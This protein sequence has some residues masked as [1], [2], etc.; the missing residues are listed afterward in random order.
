MD[1][2]LDKEK[3]YKI[4][5]DKLLELQKNSQDLTETDWTNAKLHF[6]IQVDDNRYIRY[7]LAKLLKKNKKISDED[8]RRDHL[9]SIQK[10]AK[11]NTVYC[12]SIYPK[13]YYEVTK[14]HYQGASGGGMPPE[15]FQVVQELRNIK[16][17]GLSKLLDKY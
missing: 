8:L 13:S 6:F 1:D 9:L 16:W 4:R 14:N 17:K 5:K 3:S 15:I 2:I 12:N 7:H 10:L 11:P